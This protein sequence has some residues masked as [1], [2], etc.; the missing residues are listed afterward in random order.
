MGADNCAQVLRVATVKC[1][2]RA[3]A[4]HNLRELQS[5]LG[6]DNDRIDT[7][8]IY[9]NTILAG[10]TTADEVSNEA[11]R[12]MLE[13]GI[14]KPRKNCALA[15]EIVISL[16]PQLL[17]DKA[18]F[19]ADALAWAKTFYRLPVL[20]CVIHFDEAAPHAHILLLPLIDGR[21][22]GRDAVGGLARIYAAQ[23]SFFDC[24][25]Q[26]Y[27]LTRPKKQRRICTEDRAKSASLVLTA[28]QGDPGL[29]DM[30]DVGA[31]LME[32]IGRNPERVMS[33]LGISIPNSPNREKKWVSTFIKQC[34]EKPSKRKKITGQTNA[35]AVSTGINATAMSLLAVSDKAHSNGLFE[36][37]QSPL[38]GDHFPSL[39]CN[40]QGV[41]KGEAESRVWIY[42]PEEFCATRRGGG[43]AYLSAAVVNL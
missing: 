13:A 12:L 28:L 30:P 27:G 26:P 5:E 24:V 16:P 39:E 36:P 17:V 1:T 42:A 19:F 25:G 43:I 31:A 9:L 32:L 6:A 8:R 20:S 29:M 35:I 40:D 38:L 10:A 4:K 18:A 2:V 15:I 41:R 14:E 33:A 7:G 37:T 21:M 11:K 23:T 22:R 3:A 34:P